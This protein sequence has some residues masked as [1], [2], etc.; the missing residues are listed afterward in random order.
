MLSE[1]LTNTGSAPLNISAATITG[2]AFSIGGLDLP[3]TLAPNQS[4]TF[5][6]TF[7]PS[8]AGSASATLVIT[9]TAPNS[10][11]DIAL[12]GE[13]MA[14][15]QLVVSPATLSFGNVV[16]GA[17]NSLNGTV[18]ATGASVTITSASMKSNEFLLSGIS[19]PLTLTTG[20]SASFTVQFAPAASGSV[21]SLV[22]FLSDAANS[23]TTAVLTGTGTTAPQHSVALA[24]DASAGPDVVGY[25]VY[26]RASSSGPYSKIN[27][28]IE[29][30]TAYTDAT[31]E[32]GQTYDYVTT[33]VDGNGM[34]SGDSNQA[35]ATVPNP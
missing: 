9:S 11:L 26:R 12:S 34:E 14:P 10:P 19:L 30:G 6:V 4:A 28:V 17:N 20:Q 33:A 13:A 27:S 8:G 18:Q 1:I 7:A 32:A 35:R 25:N 31:V 29:I 22:G 3:M 23:P 5:T 24:W 16:V 21:S 15:S 2:N